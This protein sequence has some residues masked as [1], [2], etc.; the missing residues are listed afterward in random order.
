MDRCQT[1]QYSPDHRYFMA[2]APRKLSQHS[3]IERNSHQK[4]ALT[5]RIS[6]DF[7]QLNASIYRLGYCF[8]IQ[9]GVLRYYRK[10][11]G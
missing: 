5:I 2:F 9:F 6:S 4:I 8:Q 3:F 11:A 10:I 1:G 7:S